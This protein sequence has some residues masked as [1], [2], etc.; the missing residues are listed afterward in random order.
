MSSLRHFTDEVKRV[1]PKIAIVLGSGQSS[2]ISSMTELASIPFVDAPGLAAPSV[3]GHSGQIVLGTLAGKSILVFQGRLH[4]YEGHSWEKVGSPVRFAASLGVKKLLLTN[5]AGGIH[6]SIGPGSLMIVRDHISWQRSGAWRRCELDRN[7]ENRPSP[8]S[9]KLTER[10]RVAGR[11]FGEDLLA[12]VYAA[13]TGPCYE[14]PAEIRALRSAGADAVGMS[15]AHEVELGV[16]LGLEC[17]AISGI[18][19]KAA[20][21]G[22]G[23]LDHGDV[24]HVMSQMRDRLS[25]LIEAF[26]RRTD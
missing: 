16:E 14:T 26:V 21:L 3:A 19:N 6:S 15:T 23:V 22:E 24:L 12:G 8:Y 10:L 11:E 4:F 2:V 1:G 13:V 25:R 7:L 20:G 9:S 5:A 17:A 18:T